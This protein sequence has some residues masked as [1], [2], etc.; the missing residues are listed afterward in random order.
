MKIYVIDDDHLSTFVTLNMLALEDATYDISTF[1]SANEA[2]E[3]LQ[4]VNEAEI[5][6]LI[7]VDLNM[8]IMDGWDFLDA[9]APLAPRLRERCSIYILTSSLD[10]SDTNRLKDYPFVSGLIQ[11]PIRSEDINFVACKLYS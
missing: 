7:F 11:K 4:E 6:E 5:P 3:A 10:I 8:P 1:L 9:L 2:L